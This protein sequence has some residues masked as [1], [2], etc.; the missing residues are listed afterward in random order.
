[1]I[2]QRTFVLQAPSGSDPVINDG[3]ASVPFDTSLVFN[4]G[5][6]LKLQNASLFVQNQGSSLLALGGV[7]PN[8]RVTFTSYSDDGIAGDTNNNG[9]NTVPRG[10]DWGGIVFRNFNQ[11]GPGRTNTF[12]IDITL[13]GPNGSKAVSGADD[14]LSSINFARGPLRRRHRSPSDPGSRAT[15]RSPCTT[16][17]PTLTNTDRSTAAVTSSQATISGD[18]DSFR[19]DDTWPA[20]R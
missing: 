9:T 10:G 5:S 2:S 8:D 11:A 3:S 17:G 6:T 13:A 7:N 14:A 12:P 20:A 19:E 16:A 1:M 18:L 4:P 15:T